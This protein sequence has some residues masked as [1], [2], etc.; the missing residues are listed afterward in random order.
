M[1]SFLTPE[2]VYTYSM[3]NETTM[4]DDETMDKIAELAADTLRERIMEDYGDLIHDAVADAVYSVLGD[5]V[6]EDY[7]EFQQYYVMSQITNRIA[8]VAE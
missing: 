8:I 1:G 4:P 7:S 3:E 2:T 6:V 5:A